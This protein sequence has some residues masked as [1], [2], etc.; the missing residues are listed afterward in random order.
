[1]YRL[2]IKAEKGRPTFRS[3]AETEVLEIEEQQ[4]TSLAER[5]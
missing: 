4:V 5:V 3:S 2:L 1:M